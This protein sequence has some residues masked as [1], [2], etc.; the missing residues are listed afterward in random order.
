MQTTFHYNDIARKQPH[1]VIF[2]PLMH[3]WV[4]VVTFCSFV[5]STIGFPDPE[6]V[7]LAV[8]INIPAYSE[9]EILQIKVLRRPFLKN[10]TWP[11]H[12]HLSKCKH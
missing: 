10:S 2:D 7:G 5:T 9:A 12:R 8:K 6:N 3:L 4:N 11:P 1:R